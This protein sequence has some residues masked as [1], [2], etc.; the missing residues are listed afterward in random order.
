MPATFCS[1][2]IAAPCDFMVSSLKT[3]RKRPVVWAPPWLA[4]MP[5]CGASAEE[6]FVPLRDDWR[7][8]GLLGERRAMRVSF[9]RSVSGV[10]QGSDLGVIARLNP[11]ESAFLQN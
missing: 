1:D 8:A 2:C 10:Q 11:D 9:G 3:T 7:E 4:G 6:P 5:P